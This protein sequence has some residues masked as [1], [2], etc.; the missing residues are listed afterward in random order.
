MGA[1]VVH[2]FMTLDGVIDNP[3]WSV[4]YGFDLKMGGAIAEIMQGSEAL[5]MGRNTY[6]L[7]A[8][9]WPTRTAEED[10]GAPFMNESPST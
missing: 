2:E 4:E 1:V 9:T 6:E 5:L 10:P 7:F 3:A 8:P